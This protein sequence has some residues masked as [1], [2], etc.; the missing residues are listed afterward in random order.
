LVWFFEGGGFIILINL[1]LVLE[2]LKMK[3]P[4]ALNSTASLVITLIIAAFVYSGHGQSSKSADVCVSGVEAVC[5][6][7]Y[8]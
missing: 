5:A 8:P 2:P 4:L 6:F 7:I 3:K 1:N